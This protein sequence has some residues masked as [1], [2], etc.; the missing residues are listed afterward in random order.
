MIRGSKNVVEHPGPAT[1]TVSVDILDAAD[2]T[3]GEADAEAQK[4]VADLF[5]HL[6]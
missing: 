5:G 6:L 3:W 1:Y 4:V 2:K